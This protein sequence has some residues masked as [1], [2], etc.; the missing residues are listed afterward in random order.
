ML[1]GVEVVEGTPHESSSD[2]G[3]SCS[4]KNGRHRGGV[5]DAALLDAARA[6]A[7]EMNELL[8]KELEQRWQFW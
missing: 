2:C 6:E 5:D 3:N 8:L 1:R 7:S 4:S